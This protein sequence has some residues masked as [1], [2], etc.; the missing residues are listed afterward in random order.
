MR[1]YIALFLM[2]IL[3]AGCAQPE[4]TADENRV[5]DGVTTEPIQECIGPVC[6]IDGLTYATDCE[7][8]VAGAE[9]DHMGACLEIETCSDSDGGMDVTVAGTVSKGDQSHDDYCDGEGRLQEYNCVDNSMT[10]I[11][12]ECADGQECMDG[13]CVEAE[14]EAPVDETPVV[15]TTGCHGPYDPDIY[16]RDSATHNGTEYADECIEFDV[17]KDYICRDGKLETLNNECPPG[18]GCNQG[19]CEEQPY[20]CNEADLGNDTSTR[21]RTYVSRGLNVVFDQSDECVDIATIKE[22]YCLLNG[23]AATQEFECG[24][25]MKCLSGKCVKSKCSET[26][27]GLDIYK[28]GTTSASGVEE[29][30]ECITDYEVREYYCHGDEVYSK[31]TH[32]GEGFICSSSNDKCV[33]GSIED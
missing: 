5:G 13:R 7:A 11:A 27:G 1:G 29:E 21:S 12:F 18:F 8:E 9:V 32:C 28:K 19:L 22:H 3:A 14:P 23:T 25:G 30:D 17:V 4:A 26:D 6:G 33:E 2:A 20:I 31:I 10:A 15:E 24:S 16:S